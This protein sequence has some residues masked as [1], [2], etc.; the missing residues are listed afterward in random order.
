MIRQPRS[1]PASALKAILCTLQ[2]EAAVTFLLT[3]S[4]TITVNGRF[5]PT[6]ARPKPPFGAGWTFQ[7]AGLAACSAAKKG[8]L[9]RAPQCCSEKD[10]KSTNKGQHGA[11]LAFWGPSL[12]E[13][14]CDWWANGRSL[15]LMQ[16]SGGRRKRDET[17]RPRCLAELSW[18][19]YW[20]ILDF[21]FFLKNICLFLWTF[22]AALILLS[23]C[24]L[25]TNYLSENCMCNPALSIYTACT[26][27]NYWDSLRRWDVIVLWDHIKHT[28]IK[29]FAR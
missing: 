27:N 4:D 19:R 22:S 11:E 3:H 6:F 15:S 28:I 10:R 25:C 1:S 9:L 13:R 8:Q 16:M 7:H 21:F 17:E 14:S 5:I 29:W 2:V 23:P 12:H 24:P 18:I 26:K 20:R